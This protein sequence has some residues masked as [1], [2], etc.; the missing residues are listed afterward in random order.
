MLGMFGTRMWMR[1]RKEQ[2]KG[3]EPKNAGGCGILR[4]RPEEG[5]VADTKGMHRWWWDDCVL[6]ML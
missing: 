5:G 4:A 6:E 3:F 1:K 2:G